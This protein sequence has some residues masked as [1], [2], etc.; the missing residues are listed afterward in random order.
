MAKPPAQKIVTKKHLA[1]QEKDRNLNRILL[2][3]LSAI[4]VLIVG[5][6]VYGILD[7][8]V[9]KGNRVVAEI[10]AE[11]I[12][13]SEFQKEV[14]FARFLQ[15]RQYNQ[16]VSNPLLVQFY[17]QQLQSMQ[18]ELADPKI[19]GKQ[20]IDQMVSDAVVE[21]EAKKLGL[22]VTDEELDA[23][24]QEAFG[25]FANGTPTIAPTGTPFATA[26]L[27]AQQETWLPPTP[28]AAPTL[29]PAPETATPT[30]APT[31][32]PPPA[33]PTAEGPTATAAPTETPFPTPTEITE[34]GSKT[35]LSEF[36]AE[37]KVSGYTE[38]DLRA[39]VRRGLIREKVYNALTADLPKEEE[40]VWA[41]HILVAT[42]E[43]AKAVIDR[44][45]KDEDFGALA[46][47]L[48]TDPGSKDNGGDLG[49]FGKGVMD[50]D[51]EAGTYA[52]EIGQI[53]QPVKSG[54]GYHVIQLLGRQ[55]LPLTDSEMTTKK[56]N[57]YTEWL[58]KAKD[59]NGAKTYD[60][61]Q[62]VSPAEPAFTPA[63]QTSSN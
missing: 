47:E 13:V 8:R 59:D 16:I 1:R 51:F 23:A 29:T 2:I 5:V 22:T 42:E 10:G 36:L 55:V 24:M 32:T 14:R 3:S 4:V 21:A 18:A 12:T 46:A 39:Y 28:T 34:A 56:Q 57:F 48:S 6:I 26:T 60:L 43:E 38:A 61:W 37:A 27:S 30:S 44:L 11:K 58:L 33:T 19:T 41:R 63:A 54:F 40:K 25:Y 45:N 15:I 20:V 50:P 53:S 17:G 31:N 62:E 49:W 52:L 7:E 35:L 9:F